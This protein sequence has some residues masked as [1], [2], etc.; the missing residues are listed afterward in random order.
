MTAKSAAAGEVSAG[1]ATARKKA[2]AK[3][4]APYH[5]G[6]LRESLLRAAEAMMERDGLAKLTLRAVAR[7]AG[8][9]HAAPA[10]HFDDLTGLLS[11]LAAIGFRRFDQQMKTAA[12]A[13]PTPMA[14]AL[15]MASAYLAF[16]RNSPGMF[17]LMF[18]SERLD[19]DRP[20]LR[21]AADTAFSALAGSIGE[22]GAGDASHGPLALA[23]AGHIVR[24][25]SPVHGFAML[26]LDGR[27]DDMLRRLPEGTTPEM[28]FV[29]MLTGGKLRP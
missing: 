25:W 1:S 18:R 21:D 19:M 8:V 2:V 7:E 4:V 14:G 27:L 28:L 12:A 5:H 20:E 11:E 22:Q 10:H 26:L 6:D 9:S 29:E 24:V 3:A 13:A 23:Q 16:A 17:T 15:A